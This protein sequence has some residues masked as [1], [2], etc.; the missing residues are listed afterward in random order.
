MSIIISFL[1]VITGSISSGLPGVS[2]GDDGSCFLIGFLWCDFDKEGKELTG[3]KADLIDYLY[4]NTDF[5]DSYLAMIT[6]FISG[7]KFEDDKVLLSAEELKEITE[8]DA[9]VTEEE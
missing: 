8:Q 6:K 9:A 5:M 3:K 1:I 7:D 4:A 2:S